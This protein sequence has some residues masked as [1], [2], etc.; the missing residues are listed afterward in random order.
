ME[1]WKLLLIGY[2]VL[3]YALGVAISLSYLLAIDLA[4]SKPWIKVHD[5]LNKIYWPTALFYT[6]LSPIFVPWWIV[7]FVRA[8]KGV[9]ETKDY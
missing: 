9:H 8:N 3:T 1:W 5:D 2:G 4:K 6:L 7:C